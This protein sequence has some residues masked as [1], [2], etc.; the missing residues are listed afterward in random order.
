MPTMP[1]DC[2][3]PAFAPAPTSSSGEVSKVEAMLAEEGDMTMVTSVSRANK[4]AHHR[5][6]APS[7]SATYDQDFTDDNLLVACE[8]LQNL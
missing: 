8:V 5:T 4:G 7:P 2:L 6:E 3:V 1:E